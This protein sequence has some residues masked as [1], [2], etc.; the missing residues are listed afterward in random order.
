LYAD[1]STVNDSQCFQSYS[2]RFFKISLHHGHHVSRGHGV[3]IEDVCNRDADR[4]VGMI[5]NFQGELR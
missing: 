5:H 4:F 1:A 3:E 2:V